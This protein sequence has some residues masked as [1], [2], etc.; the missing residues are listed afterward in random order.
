MEYVPFGQRLGLANSPIITNDFPKTAR[1]GLL[2]IIND[3]M[4]KSYIPGGYNAHDKYKFINQEIARLSRNIDEVDD[5]S[6]HPQLFEMPLI[7]VFELIERVYFK[8]LREVI[9]YDINGEPVDVLKSISEVK[10]YFSKEISNLLF[11][12]HLGFEYKDGV[13]NRRG[14]S[15]T[16]QS[17]KNV[18]TNV[19]SDPLLN[20]TRLYYLKALHFYG[21]LKKPDYENAIKEAI[22]A[23]EASLI[24]LFS[25]DISKSFDNIRKIIGNGAGKS[26]API[27]ESLIKL[28]GYR[29]NGEGVAH[30]TDKG[31]TV[32]EKEAELVIALSA[33]YITYFYSLLKEDIDIPF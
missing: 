7:Q 25:S 33:D 23:V 13:F 32:T 29:N 3:L 31:L 9:D 12:E 17:I 21:D 20:K 22:C 10:E 6:I 30:A 16:A 8:M 26:P 1:I 24:T 11:E 14:Y 28:Y 2:F 27:I 5:K 18:T 4:E 15:K 19:L